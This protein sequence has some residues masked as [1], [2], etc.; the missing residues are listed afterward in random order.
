MVPSPLSI[1]FLKARSLGVEREREIYTREEKVPR[2][3]LFCCEGIGLQEKEEGGE[4]VKW[5]VPGSLYAT[6]I[7]Q[8]LQ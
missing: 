4:K 3:F 5:V 8:S 6:R 7:D 2:C 1:S